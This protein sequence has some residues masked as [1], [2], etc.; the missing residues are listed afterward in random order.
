MSTDGLK[1]QAAY[2]ERVASA[3]TEPLP[4]DLAEWLSVLDN[5]PLAFVANRLL[6]MPKRHAWPSRP[7]AQEAIL[8][9]RD[10]ATDDRE[11]R[12][13]LAFLRRCMTVDTF[14]VT[15]EAQYPPLPTEP[16]ADGRLAV[17]IVDAD[18][19]PPDV[20]DPPTEDDA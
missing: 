11:S 5:G 9:W 6:D 20:Y 1:L 7:A 16:V 17:E 4:Y 13:G 8:H 15:L 3:P 2:E 12:L 10:T 19:Y 18:D 14:R